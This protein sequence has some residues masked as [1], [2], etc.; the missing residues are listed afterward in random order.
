MAARARHRQ[1]R[2]MQCGVVSVGKGKGRRLNHG[3]Q[4]RGNPIYRDWMV[5]EMMERPRKADAP[6]GSAF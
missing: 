4:S 3:A 1:A 6:P 5:E 2:Q